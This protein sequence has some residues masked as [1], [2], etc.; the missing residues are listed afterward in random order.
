VLARRAPRVGPSSLHLRRQARSLPRN[1]TPLGISSLSCNRRHRTVGREERRRASWL[2]F[3]SEHPSATC[4]LLQNVI[5]NLVSGGSTHYPDPAK[6]FDPPACRRMPSSA[7]NELCRRPDSG[8]GGSARSIHRG[9]FRAG[10]GYTYLFRKV[11][12]FAPVRRLPQCS[13]YV[14]MRP[15]LL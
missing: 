2:N 4:L 11:G 10:F 13:K 9:P 1:Q 15:L 6:A 8:L 14:Q 12:R 3:V 5:K 7:S